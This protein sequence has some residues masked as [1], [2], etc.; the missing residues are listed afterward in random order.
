MEHHFRQ[1]GG[2]AMNKLSLTSQDPLAEK[3]EKLR[4]LFPEVFVG[5]KIDPERLRAVLGSYMGEERRERYGLT[6]AGKNEALQ[7]SRTPPR[8]TLVPVPEQSVRFERTGNRIIEG[9][10]LEVLKLLQPELAGQ[11]KMI[12][13]DPPYNTGSSFTYWDRWRGPFH[14]NLL[15]HG[16]SEK[17]PG[18]CADAGPAAGDRQHAGWLSMMLPRLMLAKS[19]L[20]P[21]GLIFVSIDDHEV[22]H[23]R[24]L[25][26]EVFGNRQFLA[27]IIWQKVY[28]PRMDARGFS[29]DH[30]YVL[31]YGAGPE[32]RVNRLPFR[33]N[34]AQFGKVDER[35]G[36]PYRRRSLRKEGSNSLRADAPGFFYP[37]TAPDGTP[38]LPVKPDGTEGCWRWTRER[39]E[40]ELAA[41]NVEWV[42]VRGTWQVYTKQYMNPH[43]TRPPA[44]IWLHGEAGH[45]HEASEEL[46]RLLGPRVF[47]SPKPVR[48]IRNMLEIATSPEDD[49]VLDFFAGSGTTAQAVLEQNRE[50][51]GNRRFI[52]AQ[53]PEPTGNPAFPRISDITR[54]RV[55]RVIRRIEE[56][57]GAGDLGFRYE[58]WVEM[59]KKQHE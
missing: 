26:D 10:N 44:T 31:C 17:G 41:G 3:V 53:L 38:V 56:E 55:K 19:L 48:L 4:E 28:S 22:H 50:D 35:T 47:D 57:G 5:G 16:R 45:N 21:D 13:I 42:K 23:L 27:T 49:L 1:N 54:E 40:R 43:A 59:Q 7:N 30:D 52:L 8:G 14:G 18:L 2:A 15:V 24:L 9:D 20:R 25:L 39:Y 34:R 37:L 12:Y 6:W 29:T 46:A 51:G 11:V 58:R 32:A 36:R 33:Q